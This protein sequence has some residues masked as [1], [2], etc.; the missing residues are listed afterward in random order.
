MTDAEYASQWAQHPF[1]LL[2]FTKLRTRTS[3]RKK[4]WRKFLTGDT[5]VLKRSTMCSDLPS[6]LPEL[7]VTFETGPASQAASSPLLLRAHTS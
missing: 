5:P 6:T 2:L 1:D 3:D 7:R 4:C